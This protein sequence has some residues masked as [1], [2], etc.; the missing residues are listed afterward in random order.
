MLDLTRWA[1]VRLV[2]ARDRD[3][4]AERSAAAVKSLSRSVGLERRL[5]TMLRSGEE[6]VEGALGRSEVLAVGESARRTSRR[7]S[8]RALVSPDAERGRL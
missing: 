5:R 7:S 2:M 8:D 6:L 1:A 3:K 4:A